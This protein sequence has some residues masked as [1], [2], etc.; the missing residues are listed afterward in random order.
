MEVSQPLLRHLKRGRVDLLTFGR[1]QRL[2]PFAAS[3]LQLQE[4]CL[5][6]PMH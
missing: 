4:K 2:A 6:I 1:M 3:P 5:G